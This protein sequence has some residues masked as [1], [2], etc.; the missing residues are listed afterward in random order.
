MEENRNLG[1]GW[2]QSSDVKYEV[3]KHIAVA[4]EQGVPVKIKVK[5]EAKLFLETE[6]ISFQCHSS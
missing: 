1:M 4:E 3:P 5:W 6:L 2:I